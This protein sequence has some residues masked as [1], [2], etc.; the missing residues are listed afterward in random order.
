MSVTPEHFF[1]K[2]R[3]GSSEVADVGSGGASRD[4]FGIGAFASGVLGRF[5]PGMGARR[6]RERTEVASLESEIASGEPASVIAELEAQTGKRRKVQARTAYVIGRQYMRLGQF[7]SARE[8][9]RGARRHCGKPSFLRESIESHLGACSMQLLAEGDSSFADGD[10]HKA[11]ERYARISQGLARSE[12]WRLALFLRSACV[13]CQLCDYEQAGQAILQALKSGEDTDRALAL[14]DLLQKLSR[15]P[16]GGPNTIYA[17]EQLEEQL[18]GQVADL[19]ASLGVRRL[20]MAGA[21]TG[22]RSGPVK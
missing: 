13:Y 1:S 15:S 9:L 5:L 20:E 10:Y 21:C 16:D 3:S 17:R 8:W 14:L 7:D 11:R 22:L 2:M 12:E 19:M 6:A 4:R 18:A